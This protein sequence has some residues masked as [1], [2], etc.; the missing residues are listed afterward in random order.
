MCVSSCLKQLFNPFPFV[1]TFFGL[2]LFFFLFGEHGACVFASP[3]I[4]KRCCFLAF[5]FV[6]YTGR[7]I[8]ILYNYAARVKYCLGQG[9][10]ELQRDVAEG[11]YSAREW[12][13]LSKGGGVDANELRHFERPGDADASG[14]DTRTMWGTSPRVSVAGLGETKSGGRRENEI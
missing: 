8:R 9:R 10:S 4:A 6:L 13:H 14:V 1:C 5:Y 11:I 2:F 7:K 12:L 3:Y